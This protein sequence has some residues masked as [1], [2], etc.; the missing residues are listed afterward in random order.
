MTQPRGEHLEF[1]DREAWRAWLDAHHADVAE[2]WMVFH[3]K[4]TGVASIPYDDAVEEALCFG[5]IDSLI[6]RLDDRRYARKF[7]LR[8]P[9]SVWSP[10]NKRRAERMIA[11][12]RMTN[13]GLTLIEHAKRTGAWER[14]N[15]R[16]EA[17]EQP[18][19]AELREALEQHPRAAKG[20]RALA[21][22]E[23]RRYIGWIGTAKRSE[24]RRRRSR[25]AIAKLE[26]GEPLGM[27]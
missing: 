14:G 10:T 18:V 5:W 13:A 16:P 26:R 11:A 19:P 6:R 23:R 2:L 25:E 7:T 12:G 9:D 8:R 17:S 24:T 15:A 27:K 22:S 3:K 4:H 21:P 1:V 20:F